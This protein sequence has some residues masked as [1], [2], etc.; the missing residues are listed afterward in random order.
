MAEATEKE[1]INVHQVLTIFIDQLSSIAWQKMGLQPDPI[2]GSIHKDLSQAKISIDA[3]VSLCN[4]VE[5]QLDEADRRQIQSLVRDL[6]L[7]Y[8]EKSKEAGA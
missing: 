2:T 7:N 5:D 4:L 3:T 1:P 6:R 8:V